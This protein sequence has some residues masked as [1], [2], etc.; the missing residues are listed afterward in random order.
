MKTLLE[1]FSR[2]KRHLALSST[3]VI[4]VILQWFHNSTKDC[5]DLVRADQTF[6]RADQLLKLNIHISIQERTRGD[7]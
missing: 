4:D 7:I 1:C 3:S 2:S 6:L 5:G